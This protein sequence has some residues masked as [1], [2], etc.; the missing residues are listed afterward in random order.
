MSREEYEPIEI[1]SDFS[2]IYEV[3]AKGCKSFKLFIG[4]RWRFSNSGE[5]IDVRSPFSRKLLGRVSKANR[6]DADHAIASAAN[7]E[8]AVRGLAAVNRIE[9]LDEASGLIEKHQL[10][11]TNLMVSEAGKT[12]ASARGEIEAARDRLET[13]LEEV[14]KIYGEY[15]PGDWVKDTKNKFAL[16]MRQPVGVVASITPFNYPLFSPIA[17]IAPALASCNT[18]V[19]KPA[20]DTPV[21]SLVLAR[22][23]QL[24][25][26]PDGALNVIPGSGVEV[27]DPL[28][29]DPRV[30]AVSFTGS[31]A[32]GSRIPA[33]AG[34]KKLHLELGGKAAAIVL[35]DA[36]PDLAADKITVGVIKN[37]GQ[38]CDAI[39]RALVLSGVAEQLVEK[40]VKRFG[41]VR[42]GSPWEE[43]TQV[44]PLINERALAKVDGLVRDA[45]ERGA[46]LLVG[47]R[48]HGLVYEPT[49][50]DEVP[51]EARIM[52]EETF[53]PVLPVRKVD[54]VD[55]AI[56]IANRSDLGL[57]SAVFTNSLY[58]MWYV[59]KEL[60]VGTVSI[61]D[62][63]SHGV[64][65]FP[66]GGI[67]GS[68]IGREGLG[69]SIDE[70]TVLK[71]ISVN[72]EPT[73]SGKGAR[74]S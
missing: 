11:L 4:G 46:K 23:L 30:G 40:L 41:A 73:E 48:A 36:D 19:H 26:L 22:I 13:V 44:G 71:T 52:W 12:L 17:K 3:D 64:G 68:G 39:S 27:G 69:Y 45:V 49:L 32:I 6:E 25:G 43:G 62:A 51:L 15:I 50:L 59:S 20:S 21:M 63:P 56:Q 37:S 57:D 33:K 10:F 5:Y 2:D 18:V 14:R 54:S 38:R 55:E 1:P 67:K 60:E 28:V 61:N 42:F 66:F 74:V 34:M 29:S 7:S 24:A 9:V 35:E 58:S 53:G 8:L 65:N 72:L 70:L 16:V 47:G 31:T